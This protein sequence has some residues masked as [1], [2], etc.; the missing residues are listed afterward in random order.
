M[1]KLLS[2]IF[3]CTMITSIL[4]CTQETEDSTVESVVLSRSVS[5]MNSED[6]N[7]SE[8]YNIY[9]RF[10]DTLVYF[11]TNDDKLES[12]DIDEL[13]TIYYPK[14]YI[15]ISYQNK[16]K[17]LYFPFDITGIPYGEKVTIKAIA[18]INDIKEKIKN[19]YYMLFPSEEAE[20]L[21]N[22]NVDSSEDGLIVLEL[23]T[24]EIKDN[25]VIKDCAMPETFHDPILAI[26]APL[27]SKYIIN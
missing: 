9:G 25:I 21:E 27:I 8:T 24:I 20:I 4:G 5:N 7:H 6:L 19:S 10:N 3:I 13:S 16:T 26:K 18:D 11:G 1:R 17:Q 15:E 12:V 2:L 23:K 14:L 22:N